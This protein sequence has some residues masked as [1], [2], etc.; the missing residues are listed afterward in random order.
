MA[1]VITYLLVS[2]PDDPAAVA[3]HATLDDT[4]LEHQET[5]E[6][7]SGRIASVRFAHQ[8][9]L[10][11]AP[12]LDAT[13]RSLSDACPEATVILTVVE[14]RFDHVERLKTTVFQDGCPAGGL[15]HGYIFNIGSD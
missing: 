9:S 15:E 7:A 13:A 8:A 2:A 11:D 3:S 12:D 4:P 14:E 6:A 1:S 10:E 5:T